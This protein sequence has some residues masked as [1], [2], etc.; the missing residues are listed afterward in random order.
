MPSLRNPLVSPRREVGGGRRLGL[1]CG[2]MTPPPPWVIRL[3]LACGAAALVAGRA[4][5]NLAL[6][7]PVT[8]SSVRW[9]DPA[10]VVNGVVEWGAYAL[11][12]RHDHGAWV[13]V[14]L[15]R[16]FRVDEVRYYG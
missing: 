14:D 7:R 5:Q 2:A 15:G 11:H 6:H 10:G 3:A 8:S 4:R 12:T 13:T 9:G 1:A 16:S